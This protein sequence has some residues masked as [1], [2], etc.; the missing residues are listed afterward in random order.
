LGIAFYAL[1]AM[2]Q[3]AKS[4]LVAIASIAAHFFL[5]TAAEKALWRKRRNVSIASIAAHFFLLLGLPQKTGS[6][7]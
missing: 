4:S 3:A 6:N 2:P 7:R 1:P 5:Q